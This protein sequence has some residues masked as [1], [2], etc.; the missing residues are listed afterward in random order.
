LKL[1][2]KLN[3]DFNSNQLWWRVYMDWP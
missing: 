1:E 2:T 3:S